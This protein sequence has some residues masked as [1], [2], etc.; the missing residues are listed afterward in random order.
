MKSGRPR[1]PVDASMTLLNEVVNR[2][3]DA[4]YAELAARKAQ[5]RATPAPKRTKLIAAGTAIVLGVATGTAVVA[6]RAPD[7]EASRATKTLIEDAEQRQER[8]AELTEANR[9]LS[10]AVDAAERELLKRLDPTV[11]R[12]AGLVGIAAGATALV[13]PGLVVTLREDQTAI[14]AGEEAARIRA[15]DLQAVVNGMWQAGAEAIAVNGVRLTAVSPISTAGQAI[16]VDLAPIA[17]PYRID[18]IG[19]GKV[20]EIKLARTAAWARM[21]LL[22]NQ[23]GARIELS[24][25]STVEVPPAGGHGTLYYAR[26]PDAATPQEGGL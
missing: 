16:H 12:Q 4:G 11:A 9:V 22:R 20:L 21:E 8:L 5:G 3:L 15:T 26:T 25:A 23:Y 24:V 19:D 7:P 2:P 10:G 6:L 13:G 18:A 1:R 14:D 17:P